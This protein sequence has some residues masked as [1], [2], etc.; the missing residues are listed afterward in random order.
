MTSARRLVG[1]HA[2]VFGLARAVLCWSA[3]VLGVALL[4]AGCATS[5]SSQGPS[6]TQRHQSLPPDCTRTIT[7]AEDVPAALDAAAPGNTVCFSGGGLADADLTMTRSGTAAAPIRLVSDGGSVHSVEISADHVI[8]EGFTVAGGDGV[9]LRGAGLTARD[10][11]V[12]DTQKGG[13]T[14]GPCTDSTI[15]SNTTTHNGTDGIDI[16]GQRITVHANTISDAVPAHDGD[17]TDGIRFYGNGHRIT[18]NTIFDLSMRGYAN[19]PHPDCFQTWDNNAPPTF[20]V[21]ISGTTCRNA[22]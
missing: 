21:V 12:H 13:I 6:A 2:M 14:C 17:D 10:N 7:R 3:P 22:D 11:T 19:P 4:A 5:P 20:D 15:E 9:L 8:L 16:T 1:G 18:D